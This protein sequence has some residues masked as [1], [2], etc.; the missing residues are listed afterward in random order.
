[1][2][3]LI[4]N[5]SAD[6]DHSDAVAAPFSN[7]VA[8]EHDNHFDALEA[9][10]SNHSDAPI[11][12]LTAQITAAVPLAVNEVPPVNTTLINDEPVVVYS[13]MRIVRENGTVL[14]D[15]DIEL[16]LREA[17]LVIESSTSL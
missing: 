13:S 14:T 9:I 1:M 7:A 16:F 4:P 12:S 8:T 6:A 17:G 15:Q 2:N 10:P 5:Q 3:L 11:A